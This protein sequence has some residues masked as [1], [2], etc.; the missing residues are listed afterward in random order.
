M[1]SSNIQLVKS[2]CPKRHAVVYTRLSFACFSVCHTKI[3]LP[4][5][6]FPTATV[7]QGKSWHLIGWP[8]ALRHQGATG[9]EMN[10]HSEAVWERVNM[11]CTQ[12]F[13][14]LRRCSI[15]CYI[16]AVISSRFP[17]R[18]TYHAWYDVWNFL[19]AVH[20]YFKS[21]SVKISRYI[22]CI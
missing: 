21:F 8:V 5:P 16:W 6:L 20:S 9:C 10:S 19:K 4:P 1:L 14:M 12:V 13:L 15:T 22:L 7:Q 17:C 18:L 11:T 3:P 2:S